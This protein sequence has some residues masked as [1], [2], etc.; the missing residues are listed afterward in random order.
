[1]QNNITRLST[2]RAIHQVPEPGTV[3]TLLQALDPK[4]SEEGIA[5]VLNKQLPKF[6][7]AIKKDPSYWCS[8]EAKLIDPN[9][10][11]V[12]DH[13]SSWIGQG[14][15]Q[16]HSASDLT[17]VLNRGFRLGRSEGNSF[18]AL[19]S[20]GDGS[21]DFIQI[22]IN[23][24]KEEIGPRLQISTSDIRR[25]VS[26]WR[27]SWAESET[28]PSPLRLGAGGV[29]HSRTLL[30]ECI[31]SGRKEREKRL[32]RM[33]ARSVYLNGKPTPFLEAFPL[34]DDWVSQPQRH[35]RWFKDWHSSSA[36]RSPMH[37]FWYLANYDTYIDAIRHVG[38]VPQAM[39]W[40][41]S[42]IE[43]GE[44]SIY[45][46]LAALEEFDQEQHPAWFF[47]MVH[48]NR[49]DWRIGEKMA[50]AI[51]EGRVHLPP[52]DEAVLMRWAQTP[53]AF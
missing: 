2:N 35:E 52:H 41:G 48:G 26:D 34:P 47:F 31:S 53:Y 29:I 51:S 18:Y 7:W 46:I 42:R 1:M 17:R 4:I 10:V 21:A 50:A 6:E 44:R 13:V 49:V 43:A 33:K 15:K 11:K 14:L 30:A 45:E 40:P 38:F 36:G 39:V 28:T 8:H 24:G 5:E 9:G 19:A 25:H 32:E 20:Y 37:R 16:G 22:H 3:G 23:Q 27:Y 12:A